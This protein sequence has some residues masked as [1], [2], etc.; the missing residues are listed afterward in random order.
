MAERPR[1]REVGS[2]EPVEGTVDPRRRALVT[3]GV[4]LVL[5]L[6]LMTWG[7]WGVGL[8]VAVVSLV[9][10]QVRLTWPRSDRVIVAIVAR[11]SHAVGRVLT[12]VVMAA[13]AIF[14]VL[15]VWVV[16]F[17]VGVDPLAHRGHAGWGSGRVRT[18]VA[19]GPGGTTA[20]AYV[21]ADRRDLNRR[22]YLSERPFRTARGWRGRVVGVAVLALLVGLGVRSLRSMA[23]D[24]ASPPPRFD[25][26]ATA[27][28]EGQPWEQAVRSEIDEVFTGIAYDPYL[29]F[30]LPNFDGEH[31][32][33]DARV[34]ASLE[35]AVAS[36]DPVDIWFFG[37]STMFG[38]D[39]RGD[40]TIPSDIVRLAEADGVGVR[41]R[42]YGAPAYVNHQETLLFEELLERG[43]APDL[44][45]F[46]DGFNDLIVNGAGALAGT[47]RPGEPGASFADDFGALIAEE[48]G[49]PWELPTS[50]APGTPDGD[51]E[52]R[53]R[54]QALDSAMEIYRRG[55]ERAVAAGRRHGVDVLHFWQP[56][57]YSKRLLPDEAAMLE[58]LGFDAFLYSGWQQFSERAR[59]ALP[60]GVVD[61]STALDDVDEPVMTDYVHTNEVGAQAVAEAMYVELGLAGD[62]GTD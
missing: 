28:A 25:P 14:V 13:V 53:P 57:I 35:S 26:A 23:Q 39:Q 8:L 9:L 55:V 3:T 32:D 44:V 29:G 24:A 43:E 15:P 52:R 16:L 60:E 56:D 12:I 7:P 36:D 62:T 18:V 22:L 42:N 47:S 54:D 30:S 2:F 41:V 10:L 34:R 40:H 20:L 1:W 31:V 4:T 19:P 59:D 61:L 49:V 46:Y 33:I 37:G 58:P 50:L 27:A 5:A 51:A 21:E 48:R 6:A 11:I 45:V 38:V 17:L